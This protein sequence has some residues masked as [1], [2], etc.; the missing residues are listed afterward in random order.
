[1]D[2]LC[3]VINTCKDYFQNVFDL[4][5]QINKSNFDKKNILIVSGQ[6]SQNSTSYYDDIKIVKVTYTGLH[7]TSSIYILE[8]RNEYSNINYWVLL[9][10]TIK[11]GDHFFD[12]IFFYYENFLK[13]KK[14]LCLPFINPNVRK[15]SMDMGI[16]HIKHL[17][18]LRNYFKI[19]KT[20]NLNINNLLNLKKRLIKDEN[21]LLGLSPSIPN[22]STKF[23]FLYRFPIPNCFICNSHDEVIENLI[24]DGK[25]NQVYIK[26][27]D[28]Y[29]FQRN[30]K[31][32]DN[33]LIMN[34]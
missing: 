14:V 10:D 18:N 16:V 8:N 34:L 26:N 3:I 9:P 2:D 15:T 12:K 4:I 29:K 27:L 7:L 33:E 1:M 21:I 25:I 28:L 19:I 11:F 13:N 32:K 31:G 20:N 23:T 22:E 5:K 30:F 17:I 6:E 24:N